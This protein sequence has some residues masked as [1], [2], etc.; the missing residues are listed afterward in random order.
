MDAQ[1]VVDRYSNRTKVVKLV[2]DEQDV[3]PTNVDYKLDSKP[4]IKAK[5]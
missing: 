3:G 2:V 4:E 1:K 5:T